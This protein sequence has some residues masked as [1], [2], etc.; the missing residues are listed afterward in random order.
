MYREQ[1]LV[2]R[3]EDRRVLT[4]GSVDYCLAWVRQHGATDR[5]T[6]AGASLSPKCRL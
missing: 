2:V 3:D 1:W 4:S 6:A 5:A